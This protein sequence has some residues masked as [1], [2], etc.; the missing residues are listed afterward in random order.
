MLILFR[1]VFSCGFT[2]FCSRIRWCCVRRRCPRPVVTA[3]LV[4]VSAITLMES[5][6][7]SHYINICHAFIKMT[8]RYDTVWRHSFCFALKLFLTALRILSSHERWIWILMDFVLDETRSHYKRTVVAA[9]VLNGSCVMAGIIVIIFAS[10]KEIVET[11][12]CWSNNQNSVIHEQDWNYF[13]FYKTKLIS[14]KR[15][16]LDINVSHFIYHQ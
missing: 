13:F 10:I 5:N 9:R 3:R 8:R 4:D 11:A 2:W 14:Q 15:Y 6:D 16:L 1:L 12:I 7:A